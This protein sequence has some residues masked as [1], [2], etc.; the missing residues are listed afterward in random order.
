MGRT[1]DL[2]EED[3][4]VNLTAAAV[5]ADS[6]IRLSLTLEFDMPGYRT[7]DSPR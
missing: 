2:Q 5:S 4:L 1:G 6:A 3:T 7:G